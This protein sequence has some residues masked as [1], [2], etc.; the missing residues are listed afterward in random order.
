MLYDSPTCYLPVLKDIHQS[1]MLYA[2]PK[3]YMT[4]L[5]VHVHIYA[6]LAYYMA[7]LYVIY[8]S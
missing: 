5:Y 8:Q 1:Y 2:S 3:S 7:V 4:V 6:S